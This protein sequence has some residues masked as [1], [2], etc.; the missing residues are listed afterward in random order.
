MPGDALH[1][2]C[3]IS[4]TPGKP[5]IS[6]HGTPRLGLW[7]L[8]PMLLLRD[9]LRIGVDRYKGLSAV[10]AQ[11]RERFSRG[12]VDRSGLTRIQANPDATS[13]RGFHIVSIP[14][15]RLHV[16]LIVA[17]DEEGKDALIANRR[18]QRLVRP[19]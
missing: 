14:D 3:V 18:E 7:G 8:R 11:D 12:A 13:C 17:R 10:T 19:D 6:Y 2:E 16:A 15:H 4:V 9:N 5:W 1:R